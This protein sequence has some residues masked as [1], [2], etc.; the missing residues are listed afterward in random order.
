[1]FCPVTPLWY[2]TKT[3]NQDLNLLWPY[4]FSPGS[5]GHMPFWPTAPLYHQVGLCKSGYESYN[6]GHWLRPGLS[7]LEPS[8]P[9][10]EAA[11]TGRW[12]TERLCDNAGHCADD[13]SP[14][15]ALGASPPE[16]YELRCACLSP[17]HGC[18]CTEPIKAKEVNMFS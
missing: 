12:W 5:A 17:I 10:L 9:Y 8:S 11:D 3:L 2:E 14:C 16:R 18:A 15:S 7:W 13:P 1:M 4:S 6:P